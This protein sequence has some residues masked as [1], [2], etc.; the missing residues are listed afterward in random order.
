MVV[1]TSCKNYYLKIHIIVNMNLNYLIF[2]T[3]IWC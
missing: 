1:V 2:E 3:F